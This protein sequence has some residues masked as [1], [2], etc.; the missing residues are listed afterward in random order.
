MN[1]LLLYILI[2][3]SLCNA[4][5]IVNELNYNPNGSDDTTEFIELWNYG[6]SSIDLSGWYFSDGVEYTFENNVSLSPGA[7]LVVVRYTND[8]LA[9][10]PNITN[11]YGPFANDTK[12][13]NKGETITLCNSNSAVVCSFT[14]DDKFPWPEKADG[15]GLSLEL[16]HP[17]LPIT[18]ATSWAA[19][20]QLGGTPCAINST[21]LGDIVVIPRGTFPEFPLESDNVSVIAEVIAPTSVVSFTLYYSTNR[22]DEFSVPMFDDGSHN[23]SDANDFI[24]GGNIPSMPNTTY[25]WY[26]FNLVLADGTTNEFPLK[27]NSDSASPTMTVRLSWDGLHTDVQPKNYWQVATNTGVATSSRLYL[28]L[29]DA[30]E[31]LV[32]DISIKYNGT[33]FIQNGDFT[34]NDDGWSKTGNHSS[35]IHIS[36]DGYSALGCEKI[37]ATAPGGSSANSLNRYT[38]PDLELTSTIYT[39]TFAYKAIPKYQREWYCYYVGPTNWADLRINEFMS[40]NSSFISDDDG[41]FSDWIE[42]YNSGTVPLNLFGCMLSDETSYSNK[43]TFPP[44]VLEPDNYLLVFASGKNIS[45]PQ[46]HTSF[47]IKSEGEPLILCSR[48]GEKI[49]DLSPVAVP[50]NK[51]FGRMPNGDANLVF[52]D[53]P[54]PGSSNTGATFTTI[55]E[56]PVFSLNSCFFVGNLNL[57]LSV[58]SATAQIRYTT[59]NQTPT[60]S[61]ALYSSPI[62]LTSTRTVKARVFDVNA[63]PS[64][65]ISKKYYYGQPSGVLTSSCLPIVVLDSFGQTIPDEPKIPAR[66][67]IIWNTNGGM[68]SV[69]DPFNDYDGNIGIEIHGQSSLSFPKKQYGIE[70]RDDNDEQ[71][72][73]PLLGLPTESDWVL[74]GP[75]SDKSLMRNAIA[76]FTERQMVDYA[77]RAKFCEVILNGSYNGVYLL[78]EKIARSKNRVDIEKLE[79][80]QNEEPEISG[81]YIIKKDKTGGDPSSAYFH[82]SH[83]E[84]SY[85]YPKY[86]KITQQQRSYISNFFSNFESALLSAAP[87]QIV[88]AAEKYVDVNSFVD[89]YIHVQFVRNIDGLR[90]SSYMRK[91]RNEKLVMGPQWDYNLSLGNAD[92]IDGWKTNGWYVAYDP[93]WWNKLLEDTNF[94]RL[95]ALRW[96]NLRKNIFSTS[97]VLALVDNFIQQLGDAPD[98]NFTRWD[99]LGTYVWPNWYI[100]DTYEEEINWMK[101]WFADRLN[102]LDSSEGWDVATASFYADKT[103]VTP[104]ESI[105]FNFSGIGVPN[106]FFWNFGDTSGWQSTSTSPTYSYSSTGLFTITLKINK[107]SS[108]AGLF[109]DTSSHTNYINVIPEPN[110]IIFLFVLLFAKIIYLPNVANSV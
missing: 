84:L 99:I 55:A 9:A 5:I 85:V 74:H 61:S 26:Y 8:F 7:F 60:E 94:V 27:E 96:I 70:S 57:S 93:F 87:N 109:T 48:L 34:S 86:T 11:V 38:S 82:T 2:L 4:N 44:Y 31:I 41:D 33:E 22:N 18:N 79:P 36:S 69:M 102:W 64:K 92:Y 83:T 54:T 91:D 78:I 45:E 63:L 37:I 50:Q 106:N 28:Y 1:K 68:N 53:A 43:W 98:R 105:Q 81:G 12:L 77:P 110:W 108:S 24:Y 97:N 46:I 100:A 35:S 67:G 59:N 13:S 90:L 29:N 30:G 21:Y 40:F 52:F 19:S 75:Y 17:M 10:Y 25:V 47:K 32:D 56:S 62:I 42:I 16:T 49:D 20:R 65:V 6:S 76:Y 58:T 72:E 51:S 3:A 95:C 103:V 66:M 23:D 104:D 71:I 80:Y 15:E 107:N 14:Y 39:L 73:A 89:N 101:Q 88:A